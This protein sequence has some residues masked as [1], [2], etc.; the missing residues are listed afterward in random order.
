MAKQLHHY[1]S[2]SFSLLFALPLLAQADGE[3]S[4]NPIVHLSE[5][6]GAV[7]WMANIS[8][9]LAIFRTRSA[10]EVRATLLAN[11]QVTVL[12]MD[13]YGFHIRGNGSNGPVSGWIGWKSLLGNAPDKQ[14]AVEKFR[15]RQHQLL[16]LIAEK[17]PATGM[18]F[19]EIKLALGAPSK[20]D[21]SIADGK[22]VRTVQWTRKK[23]V[24]SEDI[25]GP[26]AIL[27]RER[28]LEIDTGFVSAEIVD[29]VV[30][31]VQID[32][33][34]ENNEVAALDKPVTI[35]FSKVVFED[36]KAIADR[37]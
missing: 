21:A 1:L 27:T 37:K 2:M 3:D 36:R 5:R 31:S 24:D 28:E 18:T 20:S 30:L 33:E 8:K 29:D 13:K 25:L 35:A 7:R 14:V 23:T 4:D 34:G 6:D 22:T 19:E 16:K 17:R 9:P 15:Q 12:E 10:R 26:L 32:L 11:Q